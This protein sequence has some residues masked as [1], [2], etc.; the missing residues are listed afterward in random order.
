VAVFG[1]IGCVLLIL[2]FEP[3]PLLLGYILGPMMEENFRRAMLISRGDLMVF[4]ER[5]VSATF[6]ALIALFLC[7]SI[8]SAIKQRRSPVEGEL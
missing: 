1:V 7:W 4:L 2:G 3:A 8:Y 6:F 5:P